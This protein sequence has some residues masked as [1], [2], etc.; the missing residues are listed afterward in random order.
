V[1]VYA[2]RAQQDALASNIVLRLISFAGGAKQLVDRM[3]SCMDRLDFFL[4]NKMFD[5]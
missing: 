5:V 4:K 3:E 1:N 2:L